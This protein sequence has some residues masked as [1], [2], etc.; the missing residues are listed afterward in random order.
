[1]LA[2]VELANLQRTQFYPD[3]DDNT[4]RNFV[5][6]PRINQNSSDWNWRRQLWDAFYPRVRRVKDPIKGARNAVRFLQ[7]RV[8]ISQNPVASA[9]VM[10]CWDDGLTDESHFNE[11][12]IAVLRSIGIAAQQN[13]NGTIEIWTGKEWL[14]A[15]RPFLETWLR[16]VNVPEDPS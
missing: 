9:S 1:L 15:P 11:L 4:Y 6:S 7:E 8:G 12:Y 13:N 10:S 2:H 16:S 3:L 14:P 5:L